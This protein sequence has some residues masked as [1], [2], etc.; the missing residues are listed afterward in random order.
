MDCLPR[1]EGVCTRR[2]LEMRLV[3]TPVIEGQPDR[4]YAKFDELPGQK[5]EDFN[6][7]RDKIQ[8]LTDKEAGGKKQIINKPIIMTVYSSTCPDLTII[9]LPGITKIAIDDQ[10]QDIE[11]VTKDMCMSYARDERTIILC[12][13]PANQDMST[14]DALLM[15]RQLDP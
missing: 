2:P 1:G 14:S 11:K 7:V 15:A 12:V 4:P 5:F 8:L 9:D 13:I 3:H 6:I 10:S